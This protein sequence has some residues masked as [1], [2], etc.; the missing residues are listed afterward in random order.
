MRR[1]I[2][3]QP[4]RDRELIRLLYDAGLTQREA[5]VRLRITQPRVALLHR[6][7]LD[8]GRVELAG[9]MDA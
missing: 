5:A 6:R 1:W 2:N 9:V 7:I 8:R 4:E 3:A